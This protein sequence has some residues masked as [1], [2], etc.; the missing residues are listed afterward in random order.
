[1]AGISNLTS[2]GESTVRYFLSTNSLVCLSKYRLLADPETLY[3]QMRVMLSCPITNF[4]SVG[5]MAAKSLSRVRYEK[6]QK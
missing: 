1:M 3:E 2:V 4:G 6:E 5:V